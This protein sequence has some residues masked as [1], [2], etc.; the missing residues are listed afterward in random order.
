MHHYSVGQHRQCNYTADRA[1]SHVTPSTSID[2][3][4]L[5][6]KAK[7]FYSHGL[8]ASTKSTY[9]AGQLRFTTFC[10]ELKLSALPATEATLL[11]F[12]SYLATHNISH[13]TIKVYLSAVR[14]LHVSA[15]MHTFFNNQ[16]TPRLQL[17][18]KGV[19]KSQAST[20]PPRIRLPI[21]L[22]ILERIKTL[23]SKQPSSYDNIMI[24][25]ACCLAFFG[26]LRV[27]E[28]TVPA[29]NQYDDSCHLSFSSVCI[30]SRVNP[31]QLRITIK[32]SKTDPFRKGVDIYLGA[33]RDSICPVRGIL[34]YLA[35]RGDHQGPLFVFKDGRS[36]TRHRFSTAL[37]SLLRQL[38]IDAQSYNTHSF[39]IGAATSARQAN[40]PDS[41]IKMLG[42]WKSEAYQS[43]IRTPPQELAR[44]S[45]FLTSG[46]PS[47]VHN[48]QQ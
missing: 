28:F 15:G 33:T 7:E 32:Q 5:Q 45:K 23:L 1:S 48:Q 14:H 34:P 43:Y 46:Y 22:E 26:F 30:D 16:L 17:T 27:S 44:L 36:L 31:Q 24:W 2:L 35:I 18:L 13:T 39:R 38:Q 29:D 47:S 12:V 11:L 37:N 19:Q 8:A 3:P 6:L 9:S 21:T 4:F 42:R 41:L 10:K 20:Q 25:A 40:I